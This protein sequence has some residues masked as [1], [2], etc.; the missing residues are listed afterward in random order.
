MAQNLLYLQAVQTLEAELAAVDNSIVP[1]TAI[2][3]GNERQ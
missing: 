3:D 2:I 1:M